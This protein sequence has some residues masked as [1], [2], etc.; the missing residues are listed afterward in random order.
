[1]GH[2]EA[3]VP[4]ATASLSPPQLA[5]CVAARY[6]REKRA[7]LTRR[8]MHM[9]QALTAARTFVGHS[10]RGLTEGGL[11]AALVQQ[12]LPCLGTISP[13]YELPCAGGPALLKLFSRNA[14]RHTLDFCRWA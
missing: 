11:A 7:G 6:H 2:L 1:V 13:V 5:R 14:S 4:V 12:P 9:T 8:G 10:G 3:S